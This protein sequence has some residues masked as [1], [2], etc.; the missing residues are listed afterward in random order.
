MPQCDIVINECHNV[1]LTLMGVAVKHWSKFMSPFDVHQW[2]CHIVAYIK[3]Y[4]NWS[5]Q[6]VS[7]KNSHG[8][9]TF[10]NS[11]PYLLHG[12]TIVKHG[13]L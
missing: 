9:S 3:V 10:N 4:V 5:K 1:A 2:L 8:Q 6:K 12:Q 11:Q 7:T 13:Q